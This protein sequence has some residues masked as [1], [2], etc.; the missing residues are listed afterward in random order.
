MG[1][2]KGS[3]NKP[4]TTLNS[5]AKNT[6]ITK[7]KLYNQM[8]IIKKRVYGLNTHKNGSIDITLSKL[9]TTHRQFFIHF[10]FLYHSQ[11]IYFS[12]MKK[13]KYNKL[14][15]LSFKIIEKCDTLMLIN[16]WTSYS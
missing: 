1:R 2:P 4:K 16:F 13:N 11:S 8:V 9:S 3:K 6:V 5:I 14:K 7:K 15:N 12:K 10:K